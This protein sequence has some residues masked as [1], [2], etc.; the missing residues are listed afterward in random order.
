MRFALSPIVLALLVSGCGGGGGSSATSGS[1]SAPT[2]TPA[3]A[4]APAPAPDMGVAITVIASQPS[5]PGANACNIENAEQSTLAFA[6]ITSEAG[7]NYQHRNPEGD[8]I[9]DMTGG[10]GAGDFN[11][12]GWVD[13]YAV[14][15]EA[16][17][18]VLLKNNGDGTFEDIA[19]P[20]GVD[21]QNKGSGPSFADINGDGLLDLFVGGVTDAQPALYINQGDETFV[22]IIAESGLSFPDNVFSATW[23]D[24]DKDN[25]LDLVVTHWTNTEHE[26]YPYFWINNGDQTFTEVTAEV[27]MSAPKGTF[28][29][30]R[31]RS[32]TPTFADINN[33]SWLD[34]LFIVDN[35]FSKIFMNNQNGT[36]TEDTDKT[37]ITDRAGMGSAVG[38]YDNDGDLD[39][40]VSSISYKDGV[41]DFGSLTPGNRFYQNQG[42][43][44]FVDKTDE[45]GTRH[46]YW[47]WAACF[48]DLNNDMYL[49]LFHVNGM[50]Q[51]GDPNVEEQFETDPSRLFMSNGDGTFTEQAVAAGIDDRSLGRGI[52][53]FDYD[54]DGDQDLFISN[55]NEAPKLFC[56]QGSNNN[57]INVRVREKTT[58]TQALGARI[59]VKAGDIEQFRELRAGN[60]YV[61]QNPVEAHFGLAQI[62]TI[63]EIRIVWP[64]GEE[65]RML[66]V[67]A[68]Q[69]LVITRND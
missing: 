69:F 63:D 62:E 15:G 7:I 61:S 41:E 25:D 48:T 8:G 34:L 37:V 9:L 35:G 26:F 49:D 68:N 58:N 6:E 52:V 60:N 10:V 27:G 65:S 66:D 33:D 45:T 46:G 21:I 22:D 36:F 16:G 11:N 29:P 39:W 23:G 51:N 4:P 12:D 19:A 24:F 44:T 31:D 53:C 18:N 47:G 54:R 14:A 40:F 64:D 59:Y 67:D 43:G 42:D 32:F 28:P 30:S 50:L 3:P 20:A 56:N 13:L 38:D 2:P 5:Q 1:S 17:K 55:Y 57:F